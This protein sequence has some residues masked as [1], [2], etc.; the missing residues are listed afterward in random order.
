MVL[1][2][3]I[4]QQPMPLSFRKMHRILL[5]CVNGTFIMACNALSEKIFF[6]EDLHWRQKN[7]HQKSSREAY[8][9]ETQ[10]KLQLENALLVYSDFLQWID[11]QIDEI[12]ILCQKKQTDIHMCAIEWQRKRDW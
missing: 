11:S 4:E 9:L 8:H 5:Y 3:V 10:P 6:V 1:E 12:F 2:Y 7:E